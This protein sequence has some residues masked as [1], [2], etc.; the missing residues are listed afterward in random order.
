MNGNRNKKYIFHKSEEIQQKI[1]VLI[2][3]SCEHLRLVFFFFLY[4]QKKTIKKVFWTGKSFGQNKVFG[5]LL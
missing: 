5:D 4:G 2:V 3:Q 1:R